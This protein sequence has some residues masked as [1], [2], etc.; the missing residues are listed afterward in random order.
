MIA[1]HI[2]PTA[3][4]ITEVDVDTSR[5]AMTDV[6]RAK[7]GSIADLRHFLSGWLPNGD[8]LVMDRD[9]SSTQ[10][11]F[12]IGNSDEFHGN[13]LIIAGDGSRAI[14]TTIADYRKAITFTAG[15]GAS[16]VTAVDD[17]ATATIIA[18]LRFYQARGIGDA[19][20]HDIATN[21]G[22]LSALNAAEIDRLC[23][24]LNQE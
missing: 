2:D 22:S 20:V 15:D 1:Y 3:Q 21:G 16:P 12:S 10:G 11:S 23:G 7:I 13:A 8:A 5:Q 4:T 19:T 18:A 6:M 24:H 9:G 17:R 14:G